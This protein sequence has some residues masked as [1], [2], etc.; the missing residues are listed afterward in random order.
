MNLT[1]RRFYDE[2]PQRQWQG[3]RDSNPTR[4]W[5]LAEWASRAGQGAYIDWAVGNALLPA[6]STTIRK[7]ETFPAPA[8]AELR[9][10]RG[11]RARQSS[12]SLDRR[13][14]DA[15]PLRATTVEQVYDE[16]QAVYRTQI[17][18]R[19][20]CP[21]RSAVMF[22]VSL[23]AEGIKRV[24]RTTVVDLH[25]I[26][27][28]YDAIQSML[29]QADAGLNPLGVAKDTVP[30]DI[31]PALVAAGQTHFEQIYNRALQALQ[32]A[33]TVFDYASQSSQMLRRQ[34]DRLDDFK[35]T[36]ADREADFTSRLVEV[37]GYPYPEDCGPGKL[38][39][40]GYCETGPDLYHYMYV[41]AS[42]LMG[43]ANTDKN[44]TTAP[45]EL[46]SR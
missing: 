42:Y 8:Q 3:Y 34:Q 16:V 38:Y 27:A 15:A 29:D 45:R 7:V 36:I 13:Q 26:A 30:F 24:D 5:G 1:Y 18:S 33:A 25:E 41:D 23:P 19:A 20:P 37:F 21:R 10:R 6:V 44:A 31:D 17:T 43:D 22:S 11:L 46:S 9:A 2:D 4:A 28:Q 39:P 32:N 35:R 40:T 14:H 12:R